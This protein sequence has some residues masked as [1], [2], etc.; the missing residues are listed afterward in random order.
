MAKVLWKLLNQTDFNGMTAQA[1]T[2]GTGGG[3]RHIVLGRSLPNNNVVDFLS[4]GNS[5]N[6]TIDVGGTLLTFDGNPA[7]RNGEWRIADQA[8]NRH[9][10]WTTVAGFPKTFNASD[11]PVVM[12]LQVDG[13]YHAAWLNRATLAALAPAMASRDRGVTAATPALLARFDLTGRTALKDFMEQEPDIPE[14]P[15]DPNDLEDGR[16]KILAEIVRRQGQRK[17]RKD[18]LAAYSNRCAMTECS[19]TWVLEAAHISPY[20]GPETNKAENGLL[21]RA[22]IHTLFDLGLISVE[23][24]GRVI[25]VSAK[26]KDPAYRALDGKPLFAGNTQPSAKSLDEHF[27]RRDN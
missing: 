27:K 24:I 13:A 26:V 2:S 17:F 21:L 4:A 9:P 14:L 6:V 16:K 10:A 5:S 23:P 8:S 7:R 3:A 15:F 20:R 22:D 11:P 18:L 1:A 19:E 12:I 25:W